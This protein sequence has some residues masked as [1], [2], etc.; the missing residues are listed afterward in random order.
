MVL[1][2]EDPVARKVKRRSLPARL[3]LLGPCWYVVCD[4]EQADDLLGHDVWKLGIV[5]QGHARSCVDAE[6]CPRDDMNTLLSEKLGEPC[7]N[8]DVAALVAA[9][10]VVDTGHLRG[11]WH[12]DASDAEGVGPGVTLKHHVQEERVKDARIHLAGR[13]D[14]L[15]HERALVKAA[16]DVSLLGDAAVQAR[17]AWMYRCR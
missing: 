1:G 12:V 8:L 5:G 9:Q 7:W 14:D 4:P 3:D 10:D 15:V 6:E 13:Y 16:R 17:P 11:I 2:V